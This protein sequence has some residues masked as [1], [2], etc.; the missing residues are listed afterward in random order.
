MNRKTATRQF[1]GDARV[2]D[3]NAKRNLGQ[4]YTDPAIA[5]FIVSKLDAISEEKVVLDPACGAGEFLSSFSKALVKAMRERGASEADARKA[6]ASNV[7]GFDI[8]ALATQQCTTRLVNEGLV[9][10]EHELHVYT[11]D[12]LDEHVDPNTRVV[13]IIDDSIHTKKFDY[14][15]G[16][17]PFF[18]VDKEKKP[19]RTIL[20]LAEYKAIDSHNLNIASMF[21]YKFI[22]R[23][24]PGGQLAFILPRSVLHVCSF[25]SL[26]QAMLKVKIQYIFD[27]GK[28]FENV[29]LEQCII[30]L[31]NENSEHNV[32]HYALLGCTSKGIIE[33]V[34]YDIPQD[35]LATTADH[36]FEVFSGEKP[37]QPTTWAALKGKI[38]KRAAGNDI[39]QYCIDIQRGIG[40]QRE[41]SSTRMAPGDIAVMGGRSIF[42]YGKKGIETYRYLAES[43]IVKEKMARKELTNLRSPKIMLQ[44][45]VSSKIRIV[46]CYDDELQRAGDGPGEDLYFMTFD[47][48]TNLYLADQRYARFLLAIL[49]S[50]LVTCFLRDIVFVRAKLT[51]HL[52]K[53]YLKKIPIPH[54]TD[55]QLSEITS[56]VKELERFALDHQKME[57][58]GER[59]VPSWEEPGHADYPQYEQLIRTLNRLVYSLYGVTETERRF[60]SGQ[61]KE[62]DDFY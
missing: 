20:G 61:L 1:T 37:G 22:H 10:S 59:D 40:L 58:V 27:L 46:G 39:M 2:A 26:R 25:A 42:N 32:V 6:V 14:I 15:I 28:A 53:K 55:S 60:I 8:D 31:K 9:G 43:R 41:A 18:V 16:N 4:Y 30:V 11:I 7:W 45:L 62:F 12:A 13:S 17:P 35:Y 36:V 21:V 54:P 57:P 33:T 52:D 3:K 24:R 48:I 29:G 44:N 23:L 56:V 47:T 34:S 5:E 19:F 49:T 51:I 50:E 38:E